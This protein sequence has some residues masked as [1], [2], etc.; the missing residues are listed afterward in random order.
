M[1]A[2][3]PS[4]GSACFVSAPHSLSVMNREEE[5]GPVALVFLIRKWSQVRVRESG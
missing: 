2:G 1:K 5:M 4:R 3:A